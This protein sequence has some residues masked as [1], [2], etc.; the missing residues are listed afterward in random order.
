MRPQEAVLRPAVGIDQREDD[1]RKL[2]MVGSQG[3]VGGKMHDPIALQATL[4][5]H[6]FAGREIEGRQALR[7]GHES[8]N[9][10][11]FLARERQALEL[12]RARGPAP[13]PRR[14]TGADARVRSTEDWI[15][16]DCDS[17]GLP[18]VP[19]RVRRGEQRRGRGRHHDFVAGR[20]RS[21]FAGGRPARPWLRQRSEGNV[22]ERSVR[23]DQQTLPGKLSSDRLQERARQVR[24]SPDGLGA[25]ERRV[26]SGQQTIGAPCCALQDRARRELV[27]PH[28]FGRHCPDIAAFLSQ[29]VLEE[30]RV[31]VEQLLLDVGQVHGARPGERREGWAGEADLG[32]QPLDT[33]EQVAELPLRGVKPFRRSPARQKV[34]P[35]LL[36]GVEL[37]CQLCFS[38]EQS[39][40]DSPAEIDAGFCQHV[41]QAARPFR[42]A[43][44]QG[45]ALVSSPGIPAVELHQEIDIKIVVLLLA[46]EE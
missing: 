29:A 1:P 14:S 44:L 8:E 38:R 42:F 36:R 23:D 11:G 32:V 45:A 28:S 34:A 41:K 33:A 5:N 7:G 30:Q 31:L 25:S 9:S 20:E 21:R 19:V 18:V 17:G 43:Y 26:S 15:G 4:Q 37:P 3:G 40:I 24:Q 27:A 46:G 12:R 35:A 6:L 39:G 22:V 10:S 13:D 16:D 2:G